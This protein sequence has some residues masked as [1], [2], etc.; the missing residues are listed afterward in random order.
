MLNHGHMVWLAHRI[1]QEGGVEDSLTRVRLRANVFS[2][3]LC[4]SPAKS[5]APVQLSLS[6]SLSATSDFN[7]VD[8]LSVS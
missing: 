5:E 4:F 8:R 2:W 7:D 1:K 3:F 6:I